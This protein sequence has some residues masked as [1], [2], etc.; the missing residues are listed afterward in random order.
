MGGD[1]TAH[2]FVKHTKGRCVLCWEEKSVRFVAAM[3]DHSPVTNSST[4]SY[5]VWALEEYLREQCAV[6]MLSADVKK[7]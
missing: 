5:S 7:G 3:D 2:F 4:K 6:K 1:R